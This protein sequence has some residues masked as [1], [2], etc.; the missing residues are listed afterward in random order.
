MQI[1]LSLDEAMKFKARAAL[2]RKPVWDY[3]SDAQK[4]EVFALGEDYRNFLD[5]AKTEREAAS[6][7][8]RRAEAAGFEALE[9]TEGPLAPGGRYYRVHRNK[10]I[11]LAVIGTEPLA[12]GTRLVVSHTDAPRLDLKQNP[13]YEEM[14]LALLKTHYY[15]GIR[16]YQWL[17]RPLALHGKVVRADGSEVDILFGESESDPVLT[18]SD[19]LP[20]LAAN[21]Q[22]DKKL[23]KAFEGEKLNL[24]CGSLPIC[25]GEMKERFKLSVLHLLE[26]RYGITEADFVSA[27]IEAVP[28]GKARDV[29]F[30]G[31]MVGGYG[32]DDR[33]CAFASLSAL[34]AV[35][36]PRKTAMALFYDKEEI[37]SEGDTGAKALFLE[38][39]TAAL[40]RREGRPEAMDTLIRIFESSEA[41]SADVNAAVEPDY[42]SVHEKLNAARLGYGVCITKFTGVRGKAGSNDAGAEYLGRIRRIFEDGAV[43]WQTGELGKIDEGGGGTIAKFLAERGIET[44]DCGPALLSMHAPF[45]V[46]SKADLYMTRRAYESFFAHDPKKG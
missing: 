9:N 28:A 14:D 6:E 45:E 44:V 8:R 17:A 25:E 21:V 46:S 38:S 18:I 5:A 24:L 42:Q 31:S 39:F 16:K 12:A 19:L 36:T 43:V 15:G 40:A 1:G 22:N 34:L 29:G 10:A 37:G 35:E 32:Q 11:A 23:A 13:L 27:E 33:I 4:E 2:D 3:L 7:I 26:R 30:D 20:H 41:L